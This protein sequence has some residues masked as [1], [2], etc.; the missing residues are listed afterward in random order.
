LGVL[1][2]WSYYKDVPLS[3]ASGAV[4]DHR[5]AL[6]VGESSGSVGADVHCEGHCLSSFDDLRFTAADGE[7]LL[8]YWIESITGTTPNQVAKVIIKFDSIGTSDTYFRMYYS[9]ASAPAGSSGADTFLFF[10]DFS[11]DLSKWTGDT[12]S[13]AIVGGIMTLTA[14]GGD[15][16]MYGNTSHAGDIIMRARANLSDGDTS[17]FG[18]SVNP[19]GTAHVII[20][21]NSGATNHSRH[22]CRD[23]SSINIFDNT[24]IG[25]GSY[26]LYD[27]VRCLTGTD[28]ART[29]TDGVEN[30]SGGTANVPTDDLYAFVRAV[31]SQNVAL[32]WIYISDYLETE[33]VWGSWSAERSVTAVA[34]DPLSVTASLSGNPIVTASAITPGPL[35]VTASLAV[36]SV[37]GQFVVTPSALAAIASL[38]CGNILT[39]VD[40]NY[41]ISYVC[42]LT[43]SVTSGLSRLTIPMSSFQGRFQ[44]GDPSFLSIVTPGLSQSSD[45][46]DRVDEDDPPELSVYMVKTY[47]DGN[48][49]SEQIMAVDLEDMR[50]DEGAVNQ[51]ITLEGHRTNTYMAKSITLTGAS[52]KNLG[53]GSLRYRCSPNLYLR[54]G[55]TV[56]VNGET[57]TANYISIAISVDSQ[58]MEVSE[59]S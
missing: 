40:T 37:L 27:F 23:A 28:I 29:F 54:P 19:A 59:T 47:A 48:Q 6:L 42:Y 12:G 41:I 4:S 55:D 1:S 15:V 26:H 51:S 30:G 49:I 21:H 50:I 31:G 9:N 57:F 56:T 36:S 44:S 18:I 14:G 16:R 13:A 43:P 24:A 17:Q 8:P 45:I 25:F 34:P 32:D 39:F 58:T 33:P 52:Y 22:V 5:M 2:D 46:T 11:G 3:R 10:D 53:N 35:S 20:D 38:S 7:T